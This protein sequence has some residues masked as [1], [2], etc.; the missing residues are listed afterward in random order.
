MQKHVL[1]HCQISAY[2]MEKFIFDENIPVHSVGTGYNIFT[3]KRS[4]FDIEAVSDF[5]NRMYKKHLFYRHI[6]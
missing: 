2:I 5:I 4:K 1:H 3:K 6:K